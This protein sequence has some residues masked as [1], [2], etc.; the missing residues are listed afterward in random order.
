M[1][2][3]I[4]VQGVEVCVAQR[5]EETVYGILRIAGQVEGALEEEI[6]VGIGGDDASVEGVFVVH[7]HGRQVR[8]VVLQGLQA[9]NMEG[10][11]PD[12]DFIV[13][14]GLQAAFHGKRA[15]RRG[16][17]QAPQVQIL[18]LNGSANDDGSVGI[19]DI[20]QGG[21]G[22]D[23]PY[24]G[25]EMAFDFHVVQGAVQLADEVEVLSAGQFL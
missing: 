19:D 6:Q 4:Q 16:V 12:V 11:Q 9:G 17:Q 13:Q 8:I 14:G 21:I 3:V 20:F 5:G 23:A 1:R 22:P 15:Q 10:I 2:P 24:A 25:A 7:A 18:R